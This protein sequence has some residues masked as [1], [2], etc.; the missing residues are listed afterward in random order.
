MKR[1]TMW[2]ID[3][4]KTL[5]DFDI[6]KYN[7]EFCFQANSFKSDLKK[8]A[9]KWVREYSTKRLLLGKVVYG[10]KYTELLRRFFDITEEDLI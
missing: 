6:E 1:K 9:I 10:G 5:K 4:E 3:K 8:E 2:R 7:G